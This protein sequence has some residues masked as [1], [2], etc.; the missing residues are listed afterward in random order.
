MLT[1][2]STQPIT[3]SLRSFLSSWWIFCI[4][5]ISVYTANL[6]A[7][8]AVEVCMSNTLGIY[9]IHIQDFGI[10]YFSDISVKLS[11]ISVRR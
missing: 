11:D 2:H 8:L 1:G 5:I 7:F 6:V 3:V 9:D 4:I 10:F